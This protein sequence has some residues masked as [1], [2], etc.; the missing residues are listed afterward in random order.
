MRLTIPYPPSTNA[1]YAT[2]R[3]RRV[4]TKA[5]RVY[6]EQAASIA[7]RLGAT[8]FT[9]PVS[10]RL[11]VFRPA[12][13]GDLDNTLKSLLDSMTGIVWDDDSQVAEI[14]ARRHE[15]KVNPRVEVE[16]NPL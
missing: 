2:V 9:G 6:H 10:V 15:D 1:L 7:R 11:D 16:V 14:H 3:G 13:R 4:K 8:R 12:K 5:A